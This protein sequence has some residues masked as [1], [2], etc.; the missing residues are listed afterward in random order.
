MARTTEWNAK[1]NMA[2][3]LT[4]T[5]WLLI[6]A[7]II[8]QCQGCGYPVKSDGHRVYSPPRTGVDRFIVVDGHTV[9]YV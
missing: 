7:S 4:I 5:G 9:H 6:L 3:T 2:R 8:F 1:K